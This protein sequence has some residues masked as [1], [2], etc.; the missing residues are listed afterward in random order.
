MIKKYFFFRKH[1]YIYEIIN[2]SKIK[3]YEFI[4]LIFFYILNIILLYKLILFIQI[5]WTTTM[6]YLWSTKL[7]FISGP[8]FLLNQMNYLKVLNKNCQ[9]KCNVSIKYFCLL[10]VKQ[11]V[12]CL[13]CARWGFY[14]LI[15]ADVNFY[16]F[17]WES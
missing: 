11:Y 1:V 2:I 14:L 10:Y 15:Y 17:I 6:F 9:D 8:T 5:R 13:H 7:Q 16:V 12:K 4:H 3:Q